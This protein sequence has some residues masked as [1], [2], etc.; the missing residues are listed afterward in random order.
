MKY[1]FTG[2]TKEH[3]G[4]TLS[5]ASLEQC[6][7]DIWSMAGSRTEAMAVR[8]TKILIYPYLHRAAMRILEPWRGAS[9]QRYLKRRR[10]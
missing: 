8:P 6:L 9:R 4:V 3:N 2:Q 7:M 1:E 5:Q 10:G